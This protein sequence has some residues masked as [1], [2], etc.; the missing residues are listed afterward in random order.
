MNTTQ[1]IVV[2]MQS[3]M[4]GET[5]DSDA[6]LPAMTEVIRQG[7]LH[8]L[9]CSMLNALIEHHQASIKAQRALLQVQAGGG[10][11]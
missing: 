9:G 5:I 4:R 6:L 3:A 8:E 10:H 1:T 11:A 2:A 7:N